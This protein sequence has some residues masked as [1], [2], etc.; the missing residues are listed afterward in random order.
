MD[1]VTT[2]ASST[3]ARAA[4]ECAAPPPRTWDGRLARRLVR[5]LVGTGVTPNHLTTL[6]LAIGIAGAACLARGGYGWANGG[7]LLIVLSNFVDH[8]DG[9]LARISGQSSRAGH[10]YDLACDA[11]VTVLLF[12]AMGIGVSRQGGVMAV[13]P[14]AL[15]IVAGLAI[16][17]IF[18]LRMRIEALTGKVGTM[19]GFAAGFETEDVLYLLP[20]V[21]LCAV[22]G[23]FIAVAA[24]G[25]T[26]YAAWAVVGW[27]RVVRRTRPQAPPVWSSR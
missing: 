5:P 10:L 11:V 17:L 8:T 7:A 1:P 20:L 25:A 18:F 14:T 3:A 26:L 9:E 6:R 19:Q 13:S 12:A 23:P 15:G 21:T 4:R 16:A 27:Q 2:T 22:V 24:V